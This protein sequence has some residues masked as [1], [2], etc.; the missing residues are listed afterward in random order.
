MQLDHFRPKAMPEYAHLEN[1]PNNLLYACVVCNSQK[2]D[3]WPAK[4]EGLTHEN[5]AGFLDPFVDKRGD[6]FEC[7]ID[8]RLIAQVDPAGYLIRLLLLDRPFLRRVRE[9]RYLR[10][11]VIKNRARIWKWVDDVETGRIQLEQDVAIQL[12]RT[13]MRLLERALVGE[14]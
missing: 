7:S 5:G 8:G 13:L 3:F 6:F 1:D 4:T 11:A 12:I 14:C 9:A 10:R 2:R